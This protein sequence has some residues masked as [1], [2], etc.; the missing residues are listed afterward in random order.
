MVAKDPAC[1]M[2]C[3]FYT[4]PSRFSHT[5]S[6]VL[7]LLLSISCSFFVCVFTLSLSSFLCVLVP[8]PELFVLFISMAPQW[9]YTCLSLNLS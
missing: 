2:V 4:S 7:L 6:L 1:L 8:L 9:V 3:L 5:H